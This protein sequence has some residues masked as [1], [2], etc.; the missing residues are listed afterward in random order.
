MPAGPNLLKRKLAERSPALGMWLS[1]N[2]LAAT[3]IAAGAGFDWVLLDMEHSAYDVE[4]VERHLLAARHGGDA[5]FVVRIP[6]IDPVL[7]KRLLDAGVRSFMYP[8]VQTVDE[9]K[10]AVAATRY[11]P[12]GVRGVSGIN[13]ANRFTRDADYGATYQDDICVIVQIETPQAV[14]NIPDYGRIEGL[15]AMLIGPND[16]AANMGLFRQTG[17]PEVLAK[18]DEALGLMQ[19]TGKGIGILDFNPQNAR[20]LLERGFNLVA[21]GGD[22]SLLVS[23]MAELLG[24]LR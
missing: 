14:A 2:S 3:E 11:P 19:A 15:D 18:I 23:G 7:V 4:S 22:S 21:V 5:E 24:K 6:N 1:L 9:A 12:H 10:L 20:A 17:H 16:L 8:F 13:R